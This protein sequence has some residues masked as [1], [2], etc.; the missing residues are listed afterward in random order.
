MDNKKDTL[1]AFQNHYK[2]LLQKKAAET[3]EK[4]EQEELIEAATK[5]LKHVN[6]KT[7]VITRDEDLTEGKR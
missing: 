1:T 7:E 6:N 5:A 3:P 4:R 2:E